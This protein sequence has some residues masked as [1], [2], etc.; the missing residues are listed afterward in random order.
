MTTPNQA[1]RCRIVLVAP[2]LGDGAALAGLLRKTLSGGDA[3][4]VILD[5]TGLDEATFQTVAEQA[6]P[7][8]QE[9][10]AAALILNDTRIAGRVG[11]DGVH[12]EGRVADLAETIERHSPR[13]IV[14]MGNLRDRH[15][16]LE[17]G[18]LQPD[19]VLFGKIGADKKPEPHS[20]NIGLA[21]W[22]AG[23]VEI[24]CIVQAGNAL[25]SI[26]QAA[27]TG[28][29]FVALGAAVFDSADPAEAMR[30]ANRLLDETAPRF[31][32]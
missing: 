30:E 26:E 1:D 18:E 24:P 23:M 9:A 5:S 21:E 29:E 12:L 25:A 8:I 27:A 14:G 10:G 2:P 15:G 4:S 17:I 7:V 31:E 13:L 32:N 22:W 28:A 11:A 3:A 16:A 20:R 6:V 19:Y